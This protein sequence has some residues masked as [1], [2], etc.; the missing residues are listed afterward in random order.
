[1]TARRQLRRSCGS[2]D[3]RPSGLTTA[4]RLR[5]TGLAAQWRYARQGLEMMLRKL[6]MRLTVAPP[7]PNAR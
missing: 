7:P 4:G 5:V 6:L 3:G 2:A 1:M